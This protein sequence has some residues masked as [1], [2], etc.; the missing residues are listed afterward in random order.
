[1][2]IFRTVKNWYRRLLQLCERLL[3][4]SL[5]TRSSAHILKRDPVGW[6][7]M[8]VLSGRPTG[9][10]LSFTDELFLSLLSIH[11]A[12]QPRS[13]WSSNVVRRFGRR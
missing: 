8:L 11:R 2:I 9:K 4:I 12:Q 10:A 13:G 5:H 7:D 3:A 1:V 6:I